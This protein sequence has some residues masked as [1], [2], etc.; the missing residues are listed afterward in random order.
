MAF[1]LHI[2]T[3]KPPSGRWWALILVG[4]LLVTVDAMQG[5]MSM[6]EVEDT[7]EATLAACDRQLNE[8]EL[9]NC[10]V[11]DADKE[12][13][14]LL[15][16]GRYVAEP[17]ETHRRF[18]EEG[19]ASEVDDDWQEASPEGFPDFTGVSDLPPIIDELHVEG[20]P[21]IIHA[22]GQEGQDTGTGSGA[23]AKTSGAGGPKWSA[24]TFKIPPGEAMPYEQ[25][26]KYMKDSAEENSKEDFKKT[27]TDKAFMESLARGLVKNLS[28]DSMG[29][30]PAGLTKKEVRPF[31]AEVVRKTSPVWLPAFARNKFADN[32]IFDKAD[33]EKRE[34]LSVERLMTTARGIWLY[35]AEI[36]PEDITLMTYYSE[37]YGGGEFLYDITS[38]KQIPSDL[39]DEVEAKSKLP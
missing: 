34:I 6:A 33:H 5:E 18:Q 26:M 36:S 24:N 35:I 3:M 20:F 11:I 2:R 16:H 19:R 14:S 31:F 12:L 32:K 38:V 8:L 39:I 15:P 7:L 30:N 29:Q 13:R 22:D 4:A 9:R 28:G 37:F 25:I 27:A 17:W 21:P 1:T 23:A 10:N